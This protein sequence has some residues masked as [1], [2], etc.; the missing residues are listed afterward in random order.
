MRHCFELSNVP[1]RISRIGKPIHEG[2]ERQSLNDHVELEVCRVE[3]SARKGSA[4]GFMTDPPTVVAFIVSLHPPLPPTYPGLSVT[5]SNYLQADILLEKKGV[6]GPGNQ[7]FRGLSFYEVWSN[8][9]AVAC[10]CGRAAVQIGKRSLHDGID[11]SILTLLSAIAA[12]RP[13]PPIANY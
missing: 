2:P 1:S 9:H 11:P 3:H 10:S 12:V 8:R 5:R 4:G 7:R 13:P 6:S